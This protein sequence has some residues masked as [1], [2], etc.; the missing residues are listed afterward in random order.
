MKK[1]G[2][3]LIELLAVLVVLAILALITIPITIKMIKNA[4]ENS[5]KR[6]IE[7]YGR[8]VEAYIGEYL[9]QKNINYKDITYEM[10]K[11]N[12]SIS[13]NEVICNKLTYDDNGDIILRRCHTS[14]SKKYK[15]YNRRVV[16]DSYEVGD[17]IEINNIKF[18]VIKKSDA[19]SNYVTLLKSDSFDYNELKKYGVNIGR[20]EKNYVTPFKGFSYNSSEIATTVN[21]WSKEVFS[22]ENIKARLITIEELEQ[23]GYE[24]IGQGNYDINYNITNNVPKWIY[25]NYDYWTMSIRENAAGHGEIWCVQKAGLVGMDMFW[26]FCGIRPVIEINKTQIDS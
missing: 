2:F 7:A 18:Y 10:I 25:D 21:N 26:S 20:R 4:K 5:Y 12:I 8:T 16:E 22:D 13:G 11:D 1:K 9:I 24:K 17:E 15:Y 6:S 23:L 19:S 3:T 14:N